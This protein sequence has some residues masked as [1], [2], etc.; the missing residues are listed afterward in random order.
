MSVS[1]Q[2]PLGE[3]IPRATAISGERTET[4]PVLEKTRITIAYYHPVA[5][6]GLQMI[7]IKFYMPTPGIWTVTLHGDI[8]L[9]GKFNAWIPV[10]DLSTPEIRFLRPDPFTTITTPGTSSGCITCGA[11]NDRNNSLYIN[12]S[13]GFTRISNVKPDLVAP[14]VDVLGIY[15]MGNGMM[16]GTSVATA[17]TAGACAL[18]M[19]WGIVER[20]DV[21][22]NTN[23]IKSMLIRGCRRDA[24]TNYPS[25]QW[26]YGKLDL[27]NSFIQIRG[28]I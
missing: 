27:L 19:Q 25:P 17:I 10:M 15:P 4:R 11:Y 24:N 3:K 12:S 8:I 14:G 2:T 21:S 16:S 1:L 23:R 9:N 7:I 6:S 13:W 26:G 5:V 22:L 28:Q 20:N 18:L